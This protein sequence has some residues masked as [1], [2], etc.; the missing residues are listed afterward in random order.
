MPVLLKILV[1]M[2][3]DEIDM[4]DKLV[5]KMQGEFPNLHV[6]REWVVREAI[7]A[8][9]REQFEGAGTPVAD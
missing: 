2:M 9:Y 5:A 4:L 7:A 6:S 1:P 8:L 3:Q